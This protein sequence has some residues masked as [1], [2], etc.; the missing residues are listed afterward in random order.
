MKNAT[1]EFQASSLMSKVDAYIKEALDKT[2][3]VG[4]QA[5]AQVVYDA[6]RANLATITA[7]KPYRDPQYFYGTHKKYGPFPQGHLRDSIYQAFSE[8]KSSNVRK[9]YHVSWNYGKKKPGNNKAAPYGFMVEFGTSRRGATPFLYPAY[10]ANKG[11]L[12]SVA[13]DAMQEAM[14]TPYDRRI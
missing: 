14:N 11:I 8:D 2:A 3:R 9:E 4:A 13:L 10:A 6:A 5:M 1:S 12:A 7:G